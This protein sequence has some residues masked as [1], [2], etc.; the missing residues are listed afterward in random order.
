MKNEYYAERSP[1][2]D[3]REYL[4]G[5]LEAWGMV[6]DI[7]GKIDVSFHVTMTGSWKGNTGTL[8]ESFVFSD[9]RKD[10]RTWTIQFKDDHHFT[11]TAHDVIGEAVGTQYGN[12]VNMSYTLNAKRENGS[13]I[14]LSM[15]DWLF[16]MDEKILMNRTKM[17]KFGITVGELFITFKKL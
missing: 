8:E 4:N 16:L 7:S 11:G 15:D 10:Q 1:K 9:G 6:Y 12:A 14:E 17:K 13:T 3:L 5:P 2:L